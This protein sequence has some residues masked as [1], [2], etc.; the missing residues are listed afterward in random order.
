MLANLGAAFDPL[1]L[2]LA[3][4]GVPFRSLWTAL[5]PL[6][7]AFGCHGGLLGCLRAYDGK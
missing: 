2:S 1:F 6:W 5:G 4:F 7:D 3:R